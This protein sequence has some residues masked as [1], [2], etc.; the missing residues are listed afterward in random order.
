MIRCDADVERWGSVRR[1]G[2]S[3]RRIVQGDEFGAGRMEVIAIC[4]EWT[5]H[6]GL[7]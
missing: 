3:F 7:S 1:E 6:V 5:M 2:F 4:I